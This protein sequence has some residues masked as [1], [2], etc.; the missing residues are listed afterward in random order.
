MSEHLAQGWIAASLLR[1]EDA[2]HLLGLGAFIG[3][4]RLP[5]KQDVAFVRSQV[6]HGI[7]KSVRKP[8]GASAR[9]F[10]AADLAGVKILEAGP[11]LTN[12][13]SSPYPA[14]ADGK[15]RYAGQTI[16]ACVGA[17]RAHAEE[18]AEQVEVEIDALPAVVDVRDAMWPG[19]P[20]LFDH[21]SETLSYAP[22]STRAIRPLS[23][24]RRRASRANSA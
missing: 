19:A 24:P 10:T 1:K 16:A 12:Y 9:V 18:L 21:W 13:A 23:N 5:G 20:K 2:R 15:V 17:N 4:I 22:A 11:E 14:L 6:A 3:D 7:L 8:G